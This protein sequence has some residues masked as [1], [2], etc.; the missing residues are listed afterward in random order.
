MTTGQRQLV[1]LD[2]GRVGLDGEAETS[3][4]S[5]RDSSG[6]SIALEN[7]KLKVA[8]RKIKKIVSGAQAG[9]DRADL[10]W[11]IGRGLER[12][13]WCS[14]GHPAEDGSIPSN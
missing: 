3:L 2:L 6:Y 10:D 5:L 8:K 11:A 7:E 1:S 12:R 13:G 9:A 14:A 4:L